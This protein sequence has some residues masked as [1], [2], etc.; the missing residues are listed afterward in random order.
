MSLRVL[1]LCELRGLASPTGAFEALDVDLVRLFPASLRSSPSSG[2]WG[3]PGSSR[4]RQI[5]RRLLWQMLLGPAIR[6]NLVSR[7]DLVVVPNDHAYPYDRICRLLRRQQIPFLLVQEGIRFDPPESTGS[8]E[9]RQGTGGSHAIAAWGRSSARYFVASGVS[10]D[11][12]ALTGCPRFDSIQSTDWKPSSAALATDFDLGEVNLLFLSNPIDDLGFCSSKE[13]LELFQGF[14]ERLAPLFRDPG[15]RLLVK[16]HP[17]ESR[18]DFQLVCDAFPYARQIL[19]LDREPLHPLLSLADA[20][21]TFGSSA[22]LEALLFGLPLAVLEVPGA[23][24]L[25]D[26]VKSGAA[27]KLPAEGKIAPVLAGM[28]SEPDSRSPLVE[29][30]LDESLAFRSDAAKR[31]VDLVVDILND[32]R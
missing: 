19:V 11:R 28:T 31:V 2:N 6:W 29:S 12:I 8:T 15:W 30:Y 7:P 26:F 10:E 27:R 4:R 16:L 21:V 3:D 22:G 5:A 9:L 13:K 32:R 20:A 14:V 18:E 25:H 23:G 1:S 24:Y 17:R